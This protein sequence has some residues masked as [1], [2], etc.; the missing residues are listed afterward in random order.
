MEIPNRQPGTTYIARAIARNEAF[1]SFGYSTEF[2]FTTDGGASNRP[3][4]PRNFRAE[5]GDESLELHWE[6]PLDDGGSPIVRYERSV[7]G[8]AWQTV[9]MPGGRMLPGDEGIAATSFLF[10][11]VIG[12][13]NNVPAT[14]RLRAVNADNVPGDVA[15]T[16]ATPLLAPARLEVDTTPWRALSPGGIHQVDVRSNRAWNVTITYDV[17]GDNWLTLNRNQGT[18]DGSFMVTAAHNREPR[19]REATITVMTGIGSGVPVTRT[20]RVTQDIGHRVTFV[21]NG[22][23]G[24]IAPIYIPH[25][26]PMDEFMPIPTRVGGHG[27]AG[28]YTTAVGDIGGAVRFVDERTL[29]NSDI[30]LYARWWVTVTFDP[31]GGS[32]SQNTIQAVSGSTIPAARMPTLTRTRANFEGWFNAQGVQLTSNKVMPNSHVTYTAQWFI[33]HATG[34]FSD[35]VSFWPDEII[36]VNVRELPGSSAGFQFVDRTETAMGMWSSALGVDIEPVPVDLSAQ[37]VAVGGTFETIRRL[38]S[39]LPLEVSGAAGWGFIPHGTEVDSVIIDGERKGIHRF[40]GRRA[41]LFIVERSRAAIWSPE[42]NDIIMK[43]ILHELGH[44]LGWNGESSDPRDVMYEAT[45]RYHVLRENEIMH[46][47]QIYDRYR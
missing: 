12:L 22:G 36:R 46:L 6:E 27:F 16:T 38:Y 30:T 13:P 18:N 44:G 24:A 28:W 34:H 42:D 7:N 35:R 9:E 31:A 32:V 37:I 11:V 3:S 20:I 5:P 29:I 25:N 4:A 45:N 41:R 40:T 1:W 43:T 33:W 26:W 2:R 21:L 47:R 19:A 17:A 10:G 8:G 14:I 15:T 39:P 23:T